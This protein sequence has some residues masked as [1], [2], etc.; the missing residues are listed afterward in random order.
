MDRLATIDAPA[1]AREDATW[2]VFEEI[3]YG[4]GG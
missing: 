4:F 1:F 3:E 2:P